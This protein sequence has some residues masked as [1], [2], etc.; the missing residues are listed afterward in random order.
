VRD[1][2][3]QPQA[4]KFLML[5]LATYSNRDGVCHPSQLL[6]QRATGLQADSEIE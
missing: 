3:E 1:L 6:L 2:C 4:K 5:T